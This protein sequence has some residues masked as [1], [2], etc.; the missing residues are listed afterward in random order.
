MAEK[1]ISL[2][3]E[4][5][6][7]LEAELAELKSTKREEIAEKIKVARS[8]GDLSEN[9]EYDE[10]KNEQAI[11]ESRI[12]TLEA[13]LKNAVIVED[14]AVVSEDA[15]TIWLGN[16]I[17]VLD[18]ETGDELV[19]DIV[20]SIEADPMNGKISDD[21]PLGK[22]VLGHKAGETIEV[23]APIGMLEYKILKVEK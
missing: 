8:Y 19:Y 6:A 22:A 3:L 1:V 2:T 21:S 15:D 17:T 5:K 12:A 23:E 9:S 4:G 7:K 18:V 14:D 13:T 16:T 10:A 11:V 20:S